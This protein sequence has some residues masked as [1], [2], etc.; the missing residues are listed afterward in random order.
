[1]TYS[2]LVCAQV[3][4]TSCLLFKTMPTLF[5]ILVLKPWLIPSLFIALLRPQDIL[6]W[7]LIPETTL[8]HH[9]S[10]AQLAMA[11]ACCADMISLLLPGCILQY[12]LIWFREITLFQHPSYLTYPELSIFGI[13]GCHH[14]GLCCLAL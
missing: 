12:C 14:M 13:Y 2:L 3:Q 6:R 9:R 7:R 5:S 8:I 4:I 1:M 11:R 10:T